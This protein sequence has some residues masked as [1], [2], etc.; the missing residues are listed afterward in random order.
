MTSPVVE[1]SAQMPCVRRRNRPNGKEK[2][3]RKFLVAALGLAS[4]GGSFATEATA[5]T[6]LE[7]TQKDLAKFCSDHDGSMGGGDTYCM[8]GSGK[9][10]VVISCPV[11]GNCTMSHTMVF[12]SNSSKHGPVGQ[13]PNTT[14]GNSGK[15]P[16]AGNTTGAS[17]TTVGGGNSGNGT[18]TGIK[19][20]ANS[21][22]MTVGATGGGPKGRPALQRQ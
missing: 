2:E 19:P 20:P 3:M 22:S 4:L 13:A 8:I 6:K 18:P 5:S 21:A 10:T 14:L 17:S 11:D 15:K 12:S 7:M 16:A 9:S 1:S